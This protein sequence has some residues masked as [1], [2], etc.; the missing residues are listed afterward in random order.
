MKFRYKIFLA[1]GI[2]IAFLIIFAII[3]Y[4]SL[5]AERNIN[6]S[7]LSTQD[8]VAHLQ[9]GYQQITD[10]HALTYR[11]FTIIESLSAA[12]VKE[13]TQKIDKKFNLPTT[14]SRR[15]RKNWQWQS[16]TRYFQ[17]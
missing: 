7:L 1:P 2:A 15:L 10:A 3:A 9:N 13:S 12:E 16:L 8:S 14:S 17:I 5:Y 4:F 11:L 6:D